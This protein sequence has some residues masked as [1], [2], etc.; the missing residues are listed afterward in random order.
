MT[1]LR[2]EQIEDKPERYKAKLTAIDI[3]SRPAS[4]EDC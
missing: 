4:M 2:S 1:N 3:V